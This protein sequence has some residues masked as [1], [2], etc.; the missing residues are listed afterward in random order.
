MLSPAGSRKEDNR[1]REFKRNKTRTLLSPILDKLDCKEEM[2]NQSILQFSSPYELLIDIIDKQLNSKIVGCVLESTS[3]LEGNLVL[4]G[5][6]L[7]ERKGVAKKR[8]NALPT[9]HP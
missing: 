5:A 9:S 1:N 7:L 3:L 8:K 4:G 2:S 6:I